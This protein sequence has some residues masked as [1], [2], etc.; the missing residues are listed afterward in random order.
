[1]DWNS[2]PGV[3]GIPYL[4]WL[5]AGPAG[6]HLLHEIGVWL[7][8]GLDMLIGFN[9]TLIVFKPKGSELHD[10][11]EVVRDPTSTRPL[12]LKNADDKVISGAIHYVTKA[13]VAKCASR[14]QNGFIHGRNFLNNIVDLDSHARVFSMQKDLNVPIMLFTDFGSAFPSL[15]HEWLF[16]VLKA[17]GMP[18]GLVNF[19]KGIYFIALAVGRVQADAVAILAQG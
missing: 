16:I 10:S 7:C 6:W 2:A 18:D 5:Q 14:L 11:V 19:F 17:S 12:A 8:A 15:I 13:P 1:M 3:D 9:D 4:A